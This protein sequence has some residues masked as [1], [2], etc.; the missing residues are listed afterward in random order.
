MAEA[1]EDDGAAVGAAV[2][3]G[4]LQGDEVG[5]VGD[6]E[7]AVAPGQAHREDQPVGEDAGRLEMAVAV[8]VLQHADAALARPGGDL[9]VEV[10]ARR[11][12]HEEP[13]AVV[14]RREHREPHR[15]VRRGLLDD[16]PGGD[17]QAGSL[18]RHRRIRGRNEPRP[19]RR[20]DPQ[21]L[22]ATLHPILPLAALP[23]GR[24]P[25]P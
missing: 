6:V 11:L 9:G 14:E 8:A 16:E 20:D 13:A 18:A 10:Q 23:P 2:A 12:G 17:V 7:P 24:S 5:R 3:V 22:P 4:V 25:I 1:G 15:P 21:R 19:E